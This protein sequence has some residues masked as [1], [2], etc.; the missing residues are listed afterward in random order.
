L[1]NCR[2]GLRLG[3]IG[4]EV[5]DEGGRMKDE[6]REARRPQLKKRTGQ[7]AGA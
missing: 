3:G 6:K 4:I 5:K 1:F 7:K 2:I